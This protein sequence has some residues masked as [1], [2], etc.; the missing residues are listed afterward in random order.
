M[1]FPL[2]GTKVRIIDP[3]P[4]NL[5]LF[6]SLSSNL[7]KLDGATCGP[8]TLLHGSLCFSSCESVLAPAPDLQT[9]ISGVLTVPCAMLFCQLLYLAGSIFLTPAEPLNCDCSV[10]L[11][12]KS[13]CCPRW[14][15]NSLAVLTQVSPIYC[16]LFVHVNAA[17]V[18]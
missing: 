17:I 13:P 2:T 7:Q 14:P 10:L 15:S 12:V 8:V 6:V 11:P 9:V 5:L 1:V 4:G 16:R 18:L 3:I